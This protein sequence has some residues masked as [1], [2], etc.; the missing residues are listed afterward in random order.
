M[1]EPTGRQ[2]PPIRAPRP[3][4]HYQPRPDPRWGMRLIGA[5]VALA[6]AL[7]FIGCVWYAFRP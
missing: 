2:R 4:P 6:I 7:L 1:V 3:S 5:L